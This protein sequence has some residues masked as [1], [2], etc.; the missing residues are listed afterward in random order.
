M[1]GGDISSAVK[2]N[3]IVSS[4]FPSNVRDRLF[5]DN[6]VA[7]TTNPKNEP[8]RYLE[9]A[10]HKLRTI[11]SDGKK[12]EEA[13]ANGTVASR[14]IADLFTDC[15]VMFADIAGNVVSCFGISALQYLQ[16]VLSPILSGI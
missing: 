15:T 8:T 14:P 10:K 13:A 2:S 9:P 16:L 7:S 12:E 6:D 4:L 1:L 11:L 3:A 5:E